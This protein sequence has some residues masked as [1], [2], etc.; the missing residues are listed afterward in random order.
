MLKKMLEIVMVAIIVAGVAGAYF[1]WMG[2]LPISVTQ[3]QKAS[4][5]DASGEGKVV[6]QPDQATVSL[7]VQEAGF[8]LKQVQEAVNKK[9]ASLSKSLKDLGIKEEDIKTTGYSFYPDW[10]N[11]NSYTAQ[12]SV[13][14]VVKDLDKV[15][16]VMDLVGTLGLS[17]VSGPSFGLSDELLE[18]TTKQ[19]REIAIN[20]AKKKA[21]EL[22]GLAGMRL[23]RIVN[24]VEG[25]VGR[26]PVPYMARDAMA[27]SNQL[28]AKTETPIEPGN[29]EVNVSV[30]LSYETL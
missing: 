22:A 3:T 8:S 4:T 11:K 23:G 15:S 2:S 30:T 10:Q 16:Q 28:E 25:N 19:A 26:P 9:M 13:M 1:K 5:F 12:A 29:S 7:G 18:K 14:V 27:V 20:N 24:I 21:E 6:L 17:N